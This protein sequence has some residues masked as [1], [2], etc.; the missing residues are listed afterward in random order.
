MDKKINSFSGEYA[1]LSN[2]YPAKVVYMG[3]E[4]PTVEHAYQAAKSAY[5]QIRKSFLQ[6]K[7]PGEAKRAG[8]K[9]PM[10]EDWMVIRVS[11]MRNLLNQKFADPVL[12]ELLMKTAPAEL[13]E[14][15]WWGD[16]FWGVC[17]GEGKNV[18]GK[19]L[20]EIRDDV[21]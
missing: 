8:R 15:N 18:L 21:F 4:F 12:R 14:G 20:M 13:I 16:T 11:V 7:T 10:R 3:V 2:F 19:L 5:P 17:R 9:I 6:C 1:F